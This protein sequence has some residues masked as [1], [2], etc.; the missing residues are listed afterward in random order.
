MPRVRLSRKTKRCR[1]SS[2]DF[3]SQS[4]RLSV[5]VP[6]ENMQANTQSE[7]LVD[8]D[9]LQAVPELLARG[10]FGG[11]ALIVCDDATWVAAG[12]K[13]QVILEAAQYSVVPHSLGRMV[14]PTLRHVESILAM[15]NEYAIDCMIAVG[16]G[17]INDIT[18]YA[19]YQYGQ[20]YLCVATAAS[21]NGYS[22]ATASLDDGAVKH[23]FVCRPPHA[24]VADLRVIAPAPRRLARAGVG[25]TL[26][27]STVAADRYISHVVL[28]TPFERDIFEQLRVHETWLIQ[29]MALLRDGSMEYMRQLMHALLDTGDA[30]TR[31]R[32]SV[33]AS[34][35]EHMIAH[36][37]EMMYGKE[38]RE[39]M[40]G[41]MIAV[42][43]TSMAHMQHKILLGQPSLRHHPR[44]ASHF[45]RLFGKQ[46]APELAQRYIQKVIPEDA[47][48]TLDARFQREWPEIK[49][50]LLSLI[51]PANGIERAFKEAGLAT[52]PKGLG[53]MEERYNS[54]QAYA[55]MT[56][57][58]FT[59]LDLAAMN[60]R[61]A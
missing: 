54:A 8:A 43:T 46:A 13:L 2:I 48:A 55:Y 60:A 28:G 30:M 47:V 11:N 23:S 22:S 58:R 56:R 27:R 17:T 40:H 39:A 12:Q 32:S 26:C 5:S 59:F 61:R 18:K 34:Q 24:V 25:D 33:V 19:A 4:E 31:L 38:L 16:G 3:S 37:L 53:L 50:E 15:T 49:A 29:N 45:S 41:E 14:Q 42:T 44:E 52:S 9:A 36:T 1:Y 21:M 10:P 57:D 35:G 51:V 20:A 6:V 7:R